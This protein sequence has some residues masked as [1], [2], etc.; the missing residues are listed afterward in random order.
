[1]HNGLHKLLCVPTRKVWCLPKNK[2]WITPE[3][4]ALLNQK[5]KAFKSGDKEELRKIQRELKRE[6]RRGKDSYRRKL[7]EHL[8]EGNTRKVWKGLKTISGHSKVSERGPESGDQS[9][10]TS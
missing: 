2:P 8:E 3:I 4:K 5:R 7:E 1:M 9:W 6:T 10:A